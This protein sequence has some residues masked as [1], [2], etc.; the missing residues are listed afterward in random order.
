MP[1]LIAR[2]NTI[3][4]ALAMG[5][6]TVALRGKPW[7]AEKPTAPMHFANSNTR[8]QQQVYMCFAARHGYTV[9]AKAGLYGKAY[10]VSF[11]SI[12]AECA[13]IAAAY[14]GRAVRF[15]ATGQCF[16]YADTM[17]TFGFARPGDTLRGVAKANKAALASIIRAE[18]ARQRGLVKVGR[19]A[20]PT[21]DIDTL[22]AEG[23]RVLPHIADD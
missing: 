8:V 21:N 7:F 2:P 5:A 6:E 20:R 3:D 23:G 16:A 11:D 10:S 1:T 15:T 19:S 4:E 18:K 9:E 22:P 14:N 12:A 17:P 13:R